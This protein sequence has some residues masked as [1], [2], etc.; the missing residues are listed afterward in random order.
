[1]F[2]VEA[3]VGGP[4]RRNRPGG[5]SPAERVERLV[6]RIRNVR[7]RREVGVQ[8]AV[9]KRRGRAG[10]AGVFPLPLGRQ[11][12]LPA[13]LLRQ[14]RGKTPSPE[15]TRRATPAVWAN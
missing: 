2:V 10:A 3:H 15:S 14:P 9:P 8:I 4:P 7:I 13:G 6:R 12:E 1:M 11:V 5:Q